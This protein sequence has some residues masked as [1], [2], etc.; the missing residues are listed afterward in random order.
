MW[1]C[2]SFSPNRAWEGPEKANRVEA[3]GGLNS[4]VEDLIIARRKY[5]DGADDDVECVISG[6]MMVCVFSEDMGGGCE[7]Q[8]I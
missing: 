8:K 4:G 6:D 3:K 5:L 7:K 1:R 2:F